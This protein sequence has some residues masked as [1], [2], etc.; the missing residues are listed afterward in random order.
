MIGLALMMQKNPNFA[1]FADV[2]ISVVMG[3]TII[4]EILGLIMAKTTLKKAG[5]I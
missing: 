3:T 2:I 1:P 5:E 4:H